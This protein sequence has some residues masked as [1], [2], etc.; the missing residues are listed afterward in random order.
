MVKGHMLHVKIYDVGT[1]VVNIST[2]IQGRWWRIPQQGAT[3][4]L[5]SDETRWTL[6][7]NPVPLYE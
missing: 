7:G 4:Q 1:R 5:L 3:T 2:S 6:V